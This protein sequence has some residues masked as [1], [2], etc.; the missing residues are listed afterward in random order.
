M[1]RS[2]HRLRLLEAAARIVSDEGPASL[3]MQRLSLATGLSRATLY[4]QSGGR[5]ALLDALAASGTDVGDRSD[6]R[7]RILRA[8]REVFGRLGFDAA[9]ID[10]IAETADVGTVTVYR[11]FGD[12]DGLVAAFLEELTPRRVTREARLSASGDVR[13]DLE[14]L[15]ESMLAGMRDE[16]PII[17]LVILETL[18][19]SAMLSRVREKAPMRNVKALTT[20]FREH[21]A[22]GR[23]R[24]VDPYLL[25]QAFSGALFAFGIVAPMLRGDPICDPKETARAITD[26]FLLG[27]LPREKSRG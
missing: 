13:A 10:E 4:R 5:E 7:V 16:A 23:L 25:A 21:C 6:T 11:H 9:S 22:A 15:A 26:L 20:M 3:T 8:A 27:A 14:R 19:G 1:R 18:R 12:K 17:R 2:S 24:D